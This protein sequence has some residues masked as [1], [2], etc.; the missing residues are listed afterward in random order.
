MKNVMKIN[1]NSILHKIESKFIAE[2]LSKLMIIKNDE[3][4]GSSTRDKRELKFNF[5]RFHM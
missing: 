3:M 4:K 1:N 2:D 5:K